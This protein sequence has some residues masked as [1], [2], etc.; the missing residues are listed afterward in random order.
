MQNYDSAITLLDQEMLMRD[1]WETLCE[2]H[3]I[4]KSRERRNVT[5]RHAFMTACRRLSTLSLHTIGKICDDRDHATV[6]HAN[7]NHPSN[8]AYDVRYRGAYDAIADSISKRLDAHTDSVE[9]M[10]MQRLTKSDISS[11]TESMVS[12]YK[13]RAEKQKEKYEEKIE[14]LSKELNYIRIKLREQYKR[15]DELNKEC[16]R[17]KNLI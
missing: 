14:G 2:T 6:L 16:L 9:E 4:T 13:Q 1:F 12:V 5:Y 11:Y 10:M 3:N 8:Y 7:K 15:A 17:L